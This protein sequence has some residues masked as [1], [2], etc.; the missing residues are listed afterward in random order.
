MESKSIDPDR[1]YTKQD[2][3]TAGI[4]YTIGALT[5]C[6]VA[7]VFVLKHDPQDIHAAWFFGITGL[8]ILVVGV[9]TF[10]AG[11]KKEHQGGSNSPKTSPSAPDSPVESTNTKV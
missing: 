3:R 4:G 11:L 2:L 5:F 6:A 8:F 9:G 10:I 1:K 7:Y